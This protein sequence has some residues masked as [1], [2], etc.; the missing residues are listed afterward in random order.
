LKV[1]IPLVT[2]VGDGFFGKSE[3]LPPS[4]PDPVCSFFSVAVRAEVS[5]VD[6]RESEST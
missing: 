1:V 2:V 6:S 5:M 4:R 3:K